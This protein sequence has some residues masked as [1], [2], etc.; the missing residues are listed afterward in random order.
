MLSITYLL[1]EIIINITFDRL[2][3]IN[4]WTTTYYDG[5][6]QNTDQFTNH[7]RKK[8]LLAELFKLYYLYI[9]S[10]TRYLSYF[11]AMSFFN[12]FNVLLI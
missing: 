4:K 1:Q 10:R 9:Y 11:K 2:T 8:H 12:Q 6:Q 3:K 5:H 7:Q